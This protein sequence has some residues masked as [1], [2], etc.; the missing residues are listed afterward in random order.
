[1]ASS[2]NFCTL[3]PLHAQGGGT[4]DF[5]TL[6]NGNLSVALT[7]TAFGNFGVTSGKW[8]WEYRMVSS[9]TSGSAI[10]WANERVNSEP[11]LGYNS[12]SSPSDAQIVYVYLDNSPMTIISDAPKSGSSGGSL[13]ANAISQN[14]IIGVAA[15]FDNDKW[16]F[17][18][19]GSFT[20]MLSGQNPS[21]G[22]NPTC[23][24]SGGGGVVTIART[25]GF[26]WFPA[27][28]CWSAPTRDYT[29][30]FGQD[31][32]FGGAITAG[33]NA[34]D[35]GFGDFKYSVPTGFL[36]MCSAN[37]PIS[38]DIDPAQTDD[39]HPD[40]LFHAG[41]YTGNNT[42]RSIDIGFKPDIVL[43]K[44]A[45]QSGNGTSRGAGASTSNWWFYDSSRGALKNMML[46]HS[47][48][49]A[50][51]SDTLTSFNTDGFSVGATG[52]TSYGTENATGTLIT[53]YAW[54][55]NGGTTAS[56]SVG[57][58]SSTTQAS[59]ATGM[60]MVLYNGNGSQGQTIGHGL[61]A[62]P[63][64]VVF[65]NR[66][67]GSTPVAMDWVVALSQATGSPFRAINGDNHCL[68]FND[69]NG[70]GNFYTSSDGTGLGF[71]P[72]ST[73]F[74]V[75]NNGNAPYWFNRSGDDYIGWCMHSVEG[76]SK[77]TQ[78]T[79][80]GNADGSFIYTGMQPTMVWIK[81][82]G[83]TGDWSCF[84]VHDTSVNS[85]YISLKQNPVATRLEINTGNNRATDC[86]VDFLSNGFK[87]RTSDSHINNSGT[88]YIVMAWSGTAPF[89][90]NNTL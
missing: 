60:S 71:T 11:E 81:S 84:S 36:A 34:D 40:K 44:S 4:P 23:S 86:S 74:H 72:T 83:A 62:T 29:V 33:G 70:G 17:S 53:H 67:Q 58:I 20:D 55:L 88:K 43:F 24:A 1:M 56:N 68:D 57:N 13:S 52:G 46:N 27:I 78:Y 5:G 77:Y 14:D 2:G 38:S 9:S 26:T 76:F 48:A 49:E 6:S 41:N 61:S 69:T 21:N 73:T 59:D 51:V 65:K 30:N 16:Y 90:Y 10:G 35:N 64:L 25:A 82:I 80:N 18:I 42:A 66:D 15:D 79:G 63:E 12:P 50:T 47:N 19:N 28:G 32:T 8:Y 7:D 54:K 89:K 31:S 75:P 37:L 87:I 45:D 39:N 22:S 3:N 85:S